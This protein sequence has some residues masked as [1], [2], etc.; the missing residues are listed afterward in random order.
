MTIEKSTSDRLWD[1]ATRAAVGGVLIAGGMLVA[2]ER[3]IHTNGK[4]IQSIRE[5]RF[6]KEDGLRMQASMTAAIATVD[7]PPWLEG[8]LA[9]QNSLMLSVDERL[10]VIERSVSRLEALHERNDK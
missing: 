8:L 1:I 4:D 3:A 2:H 7:T 5:T 10:R 9:T 6:T